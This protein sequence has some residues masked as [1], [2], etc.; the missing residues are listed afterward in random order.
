VALIL[1]AL[2][3]LAF[4]G[5]VAGVL[6]FLRDER[7]AARQTKIVDD[8]VTVMRVWEALNRY[9]TRY[10][11]LPFPPDAL[12]ESDRFLSE[13]ESMMVMRALIGAD[14]LLNP[15]REVILDLPLVSP[16]GRLIDQFSRQI[17]M[18]FD[19]DGDGRVRHRGFELETRALVFALGR[20]GR[21]DLNP[22]EAADDL[23][24]PDFR[25]SGGP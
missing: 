25:V 5:I 3:I 7:E 22:A 2:M 24:A 16:E 12:A 18:K 10:G 17:A 14:A 19:F 20:N 9:Q 15:E 13:Q 4:V 1:W 23:I 11:R 6:Y 8:R 21:P